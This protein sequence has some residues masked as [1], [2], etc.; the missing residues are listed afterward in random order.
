MDASARANF[1][2][3][4][5]LAFAAVFSASSI[6]AVAIAQQGIRSAHESAMIV[7]IATSA[8]A[9]GVAAVRATDNAKYSPWCCHVAINEQGESNERPERYQGQARRAPSPR[10]Y[11]ICSSRNVRSHAA[12]A[13]ALR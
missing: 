3:M 2:S 8:I 12:D 4:F 11:W 5:V 9:T 6:K 7:R 10:T 1:V 13:Y